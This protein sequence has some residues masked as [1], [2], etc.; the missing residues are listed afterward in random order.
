MNHILSARTY[1]SNTSTIKKSAKLIRNEFL[2]YFK[3][4]LGHT[5]IR[6]SPVVPINDHTV[7]FV[8]AGMNQFKGIFLDYYDPPVMKAVNSQKCIRISGKHNDLNVV[9]SDTYH[10]TFFE[11]LGNWSFGEYFKKEACQ[12]AWDLLTK[13]YNINKD[14][15]YVTYF[16]GDEKL[17]LEPDLECRDIWLNIGVPKDRILPFGIQENFWEM[18]ISGPCGPCTE[19]HIDYTKQLLNQS[20]QISK[21]SPAL[22]ELWNIVFIQYSRLTDGTIVPLPKHHVDT[23]MGFERLVALL[24][25][26]KSNY[27]TDLFQP[28]FKTI[29]EYTKAPAYE[30]K[31]SNDKSGLDNGYRV[32]ADHSRMISVALA[33]GIIPEQSNKLRKIIRKVVDIGEKTFKKRDIL[34][35]L[36]YAV[37]ENLGDVYP[38]LQNNLKTVQKIMRF[39]EELYIRL[40]NTSGKEWKKIVAKRPELASISEWATPG[41]VP[42]YKYFQSILDELKA[43]NTLTGNVAF[44][45]YDTYGLSAETINELA[46]VESLRFDSAAFENEFEN[47]K[48]RSRIGLRKTNVD[49]LRR[50]VETFKNNHVPKTDD[51]F[52]YKYIDDGNNYQFPTVDSKIVALIGNDKTISTEENESTELNEDEIGIVLDKTVCYSME[53]GQVS[54]KGFICIKDLKFSINHLRKIDGYAIHFGTFGQNSSENLC[55]KLSI[56]DACTVSIV[57]EFRI[58]VMQHHTGAH[59]LN[60]AVKQ[61]IQGVYPRNSLVN[62]NFLKFRYNSFGEKLSHEQLKEIENRVNNAIEANVPVTTKLL[63]SL[64]LLTEDSVSLIPGEIYPYTG[65]RVVEIDVPD[66]RSKEAC[67]GTHVSKTGMLEYFCFLKYFTR[68]TCNFNLEAAVGQPA[69]SAKLIGENIQSEVSD[70]EHELKTGQ[71]SYAIFKLKSKQIENK[72]T[73]EAEPIPFLVKEDC[74]MKLKHLN[75]LAWTQ[76]KEIEKSSINVDLSNIYSTF[77]F[78]VHCIRKKL[79]YLSLEEV[80]SLYPST[81]ILIIV[82][83]DDTIKAWCSVP[84]EIASKQFNAKNWMNVVLKTFNVKYH[85]TTGFNPSLVA[86]MKTMNISDASQKDLIQKAI[87]KAKMFAF[88]HVKYAQKSVSESKL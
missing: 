20:N 37:A 29:Q 75:D 12:Y 23:G 36:A 3:N 21:N 11:M 32:L 25:G 65:I 16:G 53:G 85:P 40:Q 39:E 79:L 60:A 62:S 33:D 9:G 19:I 84:Q 80:V 59:L 47:L 44:I 17:E 88:A 43:T 2:D 8:N 74:L 30:G 34:P 61:I 35:E 5:F 24:Q 38:E 78:I 67:C 48:N 45:L 82:Y 41:L 6:S 50:H 28:L 27:D 46:E 55:D 86:S 83:H 4:D 18:G 22:T 63:N 56:G 64:E 15:L 76:E 49:L 10:H 13:G 58:G 26:K 52:K 57:P 87:E 73:A 42:G 81:P 69:I 7:P 77:P 70:L 31:F 51:S 66:L 54:D 68:G 72:L 14:F 1:C 71:V